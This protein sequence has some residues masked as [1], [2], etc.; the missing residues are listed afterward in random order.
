M[1]VEECGGVEVLS[2]RFSM[3]WISDADELCVPA[4][5]TSEEGVIF[6]YGAFNCSVSVL[7]CI[8]Y[9]TAIFK[10]HTLKV[11]QKYL[12]IYHRVDKRTMLSQVSLRT[13]QDIL[14]LPSGHTEH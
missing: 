3:C 10:Q 4:G 12:P 2:S 14:T 8:V 1:E 11:L 5:T 13:S 6:V 9:T 7:E